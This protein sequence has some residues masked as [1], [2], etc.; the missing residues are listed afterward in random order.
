MRKAGKLENHMGSGLSEFD[1]GFLRDLNISTDGVELKRSSK[2]PVPEVQPSEIVTYWEDLHCNKTLEEITELTDLIRAVTAR[3][4]TVAW[5]SD[6][7][8]VL[9]EIDCQL[10]DILQRYP[11]SEGNF[12]D[13]NFRLCN[14]ALVPATDE[15]IAFIRRVYDLLKDR[16]DKLAREKTRCYQ[17]TRYPPEM[18][19]ASTSDIPRI[20]ITGKVITMFGRRTK[21]LPSRCQKVAEWRQQT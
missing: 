1:S 13:H 8:D 5:R 10:K 7:S 11:G 18:F 3:L 14:I 21:R 6:Y 2:S 20:R 16:E 15:G 12:D 4:I 9:E 19:S 17:K